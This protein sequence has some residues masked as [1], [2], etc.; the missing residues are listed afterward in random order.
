MYA[1]PF[2]H[3]ACAAAKH[4]SALTLRPRMLAV[5]IAGLLGSG[6]Y[7]T[8]YAQDTANTQFDTAM[9]KSL[10][11]DPSVSNYFRQGARFTPGTHSV[12]LT[13][14]GLHKGTVDG[15]FNTDGKLC[16]T[17]DLLD[18]AGLI[19]PKNPP[20]PNKADIKVDANTCYDYAALYPQTVVTPHPN[21]N[22]VD[23]VVPTSALA[24]LTTD[25]GNYTHGGHAALFNY[26]VIATA[27]RY[28]QNWSKYWLADTEAGF[29]VA[30]WIVRSRQS[31]ASSNGRTTFNYQYAYAQHTF[32]GLKS[33]FQA[34]QINVANSLFSIGALYGA[35]VFPEDA[36]TTRASV[37]PVVQGTA[38]TQARIEVRQ[39][40]SLL[41]STLVPAGPFT[42]TGFHLISATADLNVTVI[43]ADGRQRRFVVPAASFNAGSTL[44]AAQGLSVAV[45]RL[46]QAGELGAPWLATA[47][48]GWKV[49][50]IANVSAGV[51]ASTP[52]QAVA[53]GADFAPRWGLF[54]SA[55]ITAS[56]AHRHER[57]IQTTVSLATAIQ[58]PLNINA[59][60]MMRTSDYR[61]LQDVLQP[62]SPDPDN[63]DGPWRPWLVG[64]IH[65]QYTAGAALN[66]GPIGT[67]SV[68]YSRS[69]SFGGQSSQRV[70]GAWTENFRQATVSLN[71]EHDLGSS[72]NKGTSA[73]LSVSIP[74]GRSGNTRSYASREDN[75][76]QFGVGYS[77]N[78]SPALDYSVGSSSNGDHDTLFDASTHL[79]TPYTQLGINGTTS[80]QG[81]SM[82]SGQLS[83]GVVASAQGIAFA[84][85][86][87]RDTFG[88]VRMDHVPGVQI[89]TPAGPVWTDHYGLAVIPTMTP[90]AGSRLSVQTT[91]LPRNVDIRNGFKVVDAGHGSVNQVNFDVVT[92]HRTLLSARQADGSPIPFAASVVDAKGKFVTTAADDGLLFLANDSFTAP[93]HVELADGKTCK[94]SYQLPKTQSQRKPQSFYDTADATCIADPN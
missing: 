66:A 41:Y 1:T 83:G 34:G 21:N 94:L 5:I 75:R 19:V 17:K 15:I 84:D 43:E 27:N 86:P 65:T 16:I 88:L 89:N 78:V 22:T 53:I 8:A 71:L 31:A 2:H 26:S 30:D 72:V 91:T 39:L 11:I 4:R 49:G 32:V 67:L 62:E 33:V 9:L 56:N 63:G 10:G 69:S 57:G 70:V 52:Y 92:V 74:L 60:A 42:L 55:N 73:Y 3:S 20:G 82:L 44:G 37:G 54:G 28:G 24:P 18:Q 13:V 64:R 77:D 68:S 23:L 90:Y 51:L 14:N 38:L 87:I 50:N 93:L 79:R 45:G 36:L 35:Q 12:S 61:D 58:G 48:N 85:S 81:N 76:T 47:S 46:Q 40:G 59:S 7:P 29:N 80:M 6:I 25:I